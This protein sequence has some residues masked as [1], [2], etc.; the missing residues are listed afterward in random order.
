MDTI[1]FLRDQ[2]NTIRDCYIAVTTP[3][4]EKVDIT[5]LIDMEFE[6]FR[7]KHTTT[8]AILH[9]V[10]TIIDK[11]LY[12]QDHIIAQ[13]HRVYNSLVQFAFPD[14]IIGDDEERRMN[15]YAGIAIFNIL[16]S[17]LEL[18][19][20][21]TIDE[22]KLMA[23]IKNEI[24]TNNKPQVTPT[25]SKRIFVVH[26]HDEEIKQATARTLEKL[27]LEAII[28]HEQPNRGKTI[29]EK[30][31]EYS[32]VGFAVVLL[33]P[34]DRG[35]VKIDSPETEKFRARQNVILELGYFL[36]R[37]GR[38]RVFV[39]FREEKN[40]EIPSDYAGV[41]YTP[42]DIDGRWAFTLAKELK[43][44]DYMVDIDKIL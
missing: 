44:A 26:G 33:S 43:E 14:D 24:A 3:T 40:F 18:L 6:V 1:E 34:D 8:K 5:P 16:V 41:I 9:R 2:K 38:E 22:L 32:D 15:L 36:G 30:F 7:Q 19:I 13:H 37:L 23:A 11:F 12:T 35:R 4:K 25:I 31:T 10:T 29:I 27:G 42:Y 39:L 17:R 28:L 21:N 20:D